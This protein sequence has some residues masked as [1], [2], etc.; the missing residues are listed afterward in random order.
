MAAANEYLDA[1]TKGSVT[2]RIKMQN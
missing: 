1:Q 2:E